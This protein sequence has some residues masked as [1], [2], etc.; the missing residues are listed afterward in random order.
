[1]NPPKSSK[2]LCPRCQSAHIIKNGSIHS[3]KQKYQCKDCG[4]QFVENPTKKYVT[5]ETKAIIDRLLLERI[6]LRGIARAVGVSYKWLQ[7]YINQKYREIPW[8][9][10]DLEISDEKI[11]LIIL[12][13]DEMWSY[14]KYKENQAWI[15]L[16]IERKTRRVIG[17]YIGRRNHKSAQKLW[18]SLPR[19]YRENSICYTDFWDAY[20]QVIEP[21]RHYPVGKETGETSHVERLNNTFRQRISRLVRQALSFS[22]NLFNHRSAIWYFIHHYNT[23]IAVT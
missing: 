14:V 21:E 6:S 10:E 17:C 15:W 4:R 9:V 13:A 1:M 16:V 12:E 22:R 7:E 8:Y 5:P 20:A 11:E 19:R 2:I 3:G 18:D 23:E